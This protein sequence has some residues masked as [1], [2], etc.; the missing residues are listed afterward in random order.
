L[1]F[2]SRL[3]SCRTERKRDKYVPAEL[4]DQWERDRAKK[5]ERKRLRELERIA[6]AGGG[7]DPFTP[8]KKRK[9]KKE[10]KKERKAAQQAPA[11]APVSLE[12]VVG[13]MRR[14]VADLDAAPTLSLPPMARHARRSVHE[15]AL[16]FNLKSKSEGKEAARYTKLIKTTLSGVQVD[17][18]KVARILGKP[19]PSRGSGGDKGKGKAGVKIRPRDGELVGGVRF[20][21]KLAIRRDKAICADLFL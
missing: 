1:C 10:R 14:F 5:A 7:A 4:H 20:H 15:L 6:A 3:V 16:A 9:G 21:T 12:T 13:H 8:T 17:E 19:P 2:Y 18:R 11:P